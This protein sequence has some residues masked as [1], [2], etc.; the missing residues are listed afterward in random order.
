MDIY[1]YITL[2]TKVLYNL[3][4]KKP[5]FVVQVGPPK[6]GFWLKSRNP[7]SKDLILVKA[8]FSRYKIGGGRVIL[9][10]TLK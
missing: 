1:K 3:H 9:V 5:L 7:L 4:D 10:F 8:I 2:K 6:W